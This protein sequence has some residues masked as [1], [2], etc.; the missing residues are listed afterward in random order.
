MYQKKPKN[1]LTE[2]QMGSLIEKISNYF[3]IDSRDIVS[4]SRK[5]EL[6]KVRMYICAL[7]KNKHKMTLT[8]IGEQLL[9]DH[10]S[11]I[12]MISQYNNFSNSKIPFIK[13]E[14]NKIYSELEKITND[15]I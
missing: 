8:K 6:V 5:T 3:Q 14:T 9:R 13:E 2:E 10:T 12:Y 15:L 11:I 1:I 7:L 4:K